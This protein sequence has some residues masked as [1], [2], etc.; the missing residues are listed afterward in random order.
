MSCPAV[1]HFQRETVDQL[2]RRCSGT[3]CQAFRWYSRKFPPRCYQSSWP[4]APLP[5]CFSLSLSLWVEC[6]CGLFAPTWFNGSGSKA[7]NQKKVCASSKDSCCL[8]SS[9]LQ[10]LSLHQTALS[11]RVFWQMNGICKTLI[12]LCILDLQTNGDSHGRP[13]KIRFWI[14][15]KSFEN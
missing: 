12:K 11:W 2:F 9:S 4:S 10:E 13:V 8:S 6:S 5:M 15:P 7:W 14:I 3:E 1:S